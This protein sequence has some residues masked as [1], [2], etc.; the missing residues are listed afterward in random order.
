MIGILGILFT[1]FFGIPSVIILLKH[2]S[3]KLLFIEEDLI[4][5]QDKL[6]KNIPELEISYRGKK[7]SDHLF[8]LKGFIF[9][10]GRSDITKDD[11][12]KNLYI[13][14]P[15]ESIWHDT[16]IIE[17]SKDLNVSLKP[18]NNILNIEFG[19]FKNEEFIYFEGLFE[20]SK[21]ENIKKQIELHHRIANVG[22]V[23]HLNVSD[24]KHHIWTVLT[25]LIMA[26]F[27]SLFYFLIIPL[28]EYYLTSIYSKNG[29]D[30]SLDSYSNSYDIQ[31]DYS[32]IDNILS[33]DSLVG[34]LDSMSARIS[35]MSIIH[36]IRS[37][38][39]EIRKIATE[40]YNLLDLAVHDETKSYKLKTDDFTVR[41]QL[42]T[43]IIHYV[44]YGITSLI[45]LLLVITFA[46]VI[47]HINMRK[48]IKHIEI[49]IS[50]NSQYSK[51]E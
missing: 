38:A 49:Q 3:R 30:I 7:I 10:K 15:S 42:E 24:Y 32:N 27:L 21:P 14:L 19:L 2:Y 44:F 39:Y 36:E 34:I 45:F 33:S 50:S 22:K 48:I 41:F 4:N 17:I 9:C 47:D 23:K 43:N 6:A 25:P 29:A 1:V 46:L 12:E 28:E 20:S 8:L 31:D 16:K 11:I 51:K 13:E 5:L 18:N 35:R 26:I 37:E 40:E